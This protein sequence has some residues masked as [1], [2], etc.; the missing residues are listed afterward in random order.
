MNPS[1]NDDEAQVTLS[2]NGLHD[3]AITKVP[4]A[5]TLVVEASVKPFINL[6][7]IGTVAL[8]GGFLITIVRRIK[9]VSKK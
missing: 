8:I 1:K 9:E 4:K 7:W 3:S 6:V 2:I 5:E